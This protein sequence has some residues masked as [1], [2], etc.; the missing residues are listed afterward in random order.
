[1]KRNIRISA[2]AVLA[3]ALLY[4]FLDAESILALLAAVAAHELGHLLALQLLGLRVRRIRMEARGFCM[5]Y[6]GSTG[7]V[8]HALAA[9]AGPG[10]GFLYAYAASLAGNRLGMDGLCLSAGMSLLLSLFNLIPALPLDGGRILMSIC[11]GCCGEQRGRLLC[12][13]ASTACGF[14]L[15]ALGTLLLFQGKGA[16]L[17]VAA[18]WVLAWQEGVEKRLEIL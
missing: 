2:G 14:V 9:A 3:A 1:M 6:C 12:A 17:L 18:V 7:A 8:G 5:D 11:C 4:Y 13:A 15:L 10:A 16:A